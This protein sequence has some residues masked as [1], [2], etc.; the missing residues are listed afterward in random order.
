VD[1]L[2]FS[3]RLRER[4]CPG[5]YQTGTNEGVE[6]F[7]LLLRTGHWYTARYAFAVLPWSAVEEPSALLAVA[8]RATR[9]MIF[10]VP[11]FLQ[12]G[13]YVV[14]VGP[15]RGWSPISPAATADQTSAHSVIVQGVHFLDLETRASVVNRSEWGSIQFGGTV[16]VTHVVEEVLA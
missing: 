12:V 6:P 9:R 5:M 15:E 14:V 13:L 4:L 16:G 1:V 10:T 2:E 3:T 8:R 11:F 7:S